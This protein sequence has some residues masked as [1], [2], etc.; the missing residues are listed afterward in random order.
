M[1]F[2]AI[3]AAATYAVWTSQ[4]VR[5]LVIAIFNRRPAPTATFWKVVTVLDEQKRPKQIAL[6]PIKHPH[7]RLLLQTSLP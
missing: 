2:F 4:R 6:H 1:N 3:K 5:T 7:P